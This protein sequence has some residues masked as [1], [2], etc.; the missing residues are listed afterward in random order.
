MQSFRDKYEQ[1]P[2]P[3]TAEKYM[4][5]N[6]AG[7]CTEWQGWMDGRID[8]RTDGRSDRRTDGQTAARAEEWMMDG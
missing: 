3:K 1:S 6:N 8:G 7:K 2:L 4:S 5:L